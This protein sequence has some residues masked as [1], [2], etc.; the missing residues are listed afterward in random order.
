MST[1]RTTR[2]GAIRT[3]P[4]RTRAARTALAT[5]AVAALAVPVTLTATAGSASA[6]GRTVFV[7]SAVEKPGDRVQLPLLRGTSQGRTV[8]YVV[9]DASTSGAADRYGVNRSNKLANARG[10]AAVQKVT[11]KNGVLD[12]PASVDFRPDRVVVPGPGGFPPAKAEPGSVG[13]A[14]YSPLVQL[15]DGTVLNA[16]QVANGTGQADKVISLNTAARTVLFQETNGFSRNRA[17][18]YVSTDA[19]DP[20]VAALEGVTY[21]PALN[22]APFVGGD[23]TNSARTSL[24]AFV[25]GQ[26]GAANRNRQGLN[27]ALLDGLDPLNVLAWS[28]NQGRYSPLWDVFPAAWTDAATRAGKNTRQTAFAD[29]QDLADAGLVTGPGGARFGAAGIVVNCPIISQDA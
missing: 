12:F 8:W 23:G 16:P 19:S 22:A 2:P 6:A 15:P 10:T 27:S 11:V 29:V 21:A 17:V 24:A 20:G 25:N 28:P 13:E 3:R 26:T 5:A 4:T 7:S 9:L 14:G 18:K 1:P